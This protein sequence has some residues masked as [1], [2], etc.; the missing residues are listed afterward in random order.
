MRLELA[1]VHETFAM[2]YQHMML[3]E[4]DAAK[5]ESYFERALAVAQ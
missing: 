3:S 4:A 1:S 2:L 5:A